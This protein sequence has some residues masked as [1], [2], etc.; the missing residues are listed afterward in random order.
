MPWLFCTVM[1][2]ESNIHGKTWQKLGDEQHD[3]DILPTAMLYTTG[4]WV[5]ICLY[6]LW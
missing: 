6:T 3:G 2:R 1:L 4:W 5:K